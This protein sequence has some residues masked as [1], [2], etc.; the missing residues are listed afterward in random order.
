M[1]LI[2]VVFNLYYMRTLFAFLQF[3][4]SSSQLSDSA[5]T[6]RLWS[7]LPPDLCHPWHAKNPM[8]KMPMCQWR[9][10]KIFRKPWTWWDNPSFFIFA[11]LKIYDWSRNFESFIP[12]KFKGIFVLCKSFFLPN[13]QCKLCFATLIF[14]LF[15][16]GRSLFFFLWKHQWENTKIV[17]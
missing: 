6:V 13:V 17:C 16:G 11:F 3:A 5:T 4:F 14:K 10:S 2:K 8:L 1:K 15:F 12:T 9:D 7:S